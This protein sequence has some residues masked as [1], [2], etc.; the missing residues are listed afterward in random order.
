[1]ND[2]AWPNPSFPMIY[3]WRDRNIEDLTREE[4]LVALR[5][6]IHELESM[7]AVR[8]ADARMRRLFREVGA[9]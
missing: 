3:A 1:M 8:E 7:R 2:G 5:D 4:L 9:Q 6:A